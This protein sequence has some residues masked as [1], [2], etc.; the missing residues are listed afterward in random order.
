MG[1]SLTL[2]D[3]QQTSHTGFLGNHRDIEPPDPIS[4]SAVKSV[5]ADDSVGFPHVKVGHCQDLIGSPVTDNTVTGLFL[6]LKE[7]ERER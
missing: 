3:K 5:I 6:W 2:T 7:R 1:R 4:N